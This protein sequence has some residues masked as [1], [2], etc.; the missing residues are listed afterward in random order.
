[1]RASERGSPPPKK[2]NHLNLTYEADTEIGA[3]RRAAQE[4]ATGFGGVGGSGGDA[5]LKEE[6]FFRADEMPEAYAEEFM[7]RP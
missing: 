4:T 7:D 5:E 3:A 6:F 1:M 2:K